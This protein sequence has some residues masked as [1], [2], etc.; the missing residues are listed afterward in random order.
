MPVTAVALSPDEKFLAAAG[1]GAPEANIRVWD[2]KSREI[3]ADFSA[4]AGRIEDMRF[5]SDNRRLLTFAKEG[6][7]CAWDVADV[8]R[9][10]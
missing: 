4:P 2:W 6:S 1:S 3:I 8:L 9:L 10:L 7:V 5:L